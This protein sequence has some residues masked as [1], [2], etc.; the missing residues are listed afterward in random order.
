MI[1]PTET[2]YGLGVDAFNARAVAKIFRAK[3]RPEG[4]PLI[5]HVSKK[6]TIDML[7]CDISPIARK[8]VK[9]FWPG[10]LTLV[11]KA[12]VCLPKS[13]CGTSMIPIMEVPYDY[14]RC[15]EIFRTISMENARKVEAYHALGEF[16]EHEYGGL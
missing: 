6:S 11:L 16:N 10:P 5:V 15:K 2:V 8:F 13:V 14:E 9:Q 3:G 7:A 12:R 4:K 1:F